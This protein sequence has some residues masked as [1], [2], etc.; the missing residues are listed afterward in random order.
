MDKPYATSFV[1]YCLTAT[2]ASVVD[3]KV[4]MEHEANGDFGYEWL[5]T[6]YAGSGAF[7]IREWRANEAVVMER[8]PN[9]AGTPAP[10]N[11]PT[12]GLRPR[13][14]RDQESAA[15]VAAGADV[16]R[17]HRCLHPGRDLVSP[18]RPVVLHRSARRHVHGNRQV[19]PAAESADGGVEESGVGAVGLRR[20]V[21]RAARSR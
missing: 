4:A 20:P 14:E 15:P 10:L 9:Y 12:L 3:K 1:L 7:T 13:V 17:R 18:R 11:T 6:N 8:N 19:R 2:V 21:G 5:K 16:W